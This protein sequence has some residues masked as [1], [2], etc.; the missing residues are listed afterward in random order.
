MR[1]LVHGLM[2]IDEHAI[3]E[4][5]Y[6]RP[7]YF[8]LSWWAYMNCRPGAAAAVSPMV[9]TPRPC[10]QFSY[11]YV[12]NISFLLYW[13]LR[14]LSVLLIRLP[15]VFVAYCPAVKSFDLERQLIMR[16]NLTAP[17]N[18]SVKTAKVMSPKNNLLM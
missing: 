8:Y 13:W 3:D 6:G 7:K 14:R 16:P 5:L 15:F 2:M 11:C 12:F 4:S 10:Y 17:N 1:I 18:H 9:N